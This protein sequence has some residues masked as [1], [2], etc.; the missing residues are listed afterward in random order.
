MFLIFIERVRISESFY[1]Y[2]H[3]KIKSTHKSTIEITKEDYLTER[4][5]CIIAI[6]SEKACA[7]LSEDI[8]KAI[9]SKFSK[10]IFYLEAKGIEEIIEAYGAEELILTNGV[11]MVIRKSNYID[12]RTIAI[13]SNK[14]A[15]EIRR[16]F[17]EAI[18]SKNSRMKITIEVING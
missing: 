11:S 2:G 4:G 1:A 17:I 10:V 18:K 3:E 5:D 14:S 12:D 15:R 16:D 8:K 13:H 6:R 7:D 9:K